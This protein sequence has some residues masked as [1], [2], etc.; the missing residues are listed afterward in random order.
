MIG[1]GVQINPMWR[2]EQVEAIDGW[3]D[4]QPEPKPDRTEA[5][6]TLVMRAI[7][8]DARR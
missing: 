2:P 5:I 3:I 6:R 1:R 7:E 8:A 4:R